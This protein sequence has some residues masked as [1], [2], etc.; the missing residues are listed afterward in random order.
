M[1]NEV[2][3]ML[4]SY[5]ISVI[6][7]KYIFSCICMLFKTLFFLIVNRCLPHQK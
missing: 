5:S 2:E 6:L 7:P 4:L 3:K 1:H